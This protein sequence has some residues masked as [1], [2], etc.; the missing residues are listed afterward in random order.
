MNG[1]F[2]ISASMLKLILLFLIGL[3]A[4]LANVHG[5][6]SQTPPHAHIQTLT[7]DNL[8]GLISLVG[9]E[10]GKFL[11]GAALDSKKL[12]TLSRDP[13][14]G[15]VKVIDSIGDLEG[16]VCL[17]ISKDQKWVVFTSCISSLVTL[18]SR[19]AETGKLTEA[20]R[21]QQGMDGVKGLEWPIA[22]TISP[23]SKF[24]YVTNDSGMGSL[25]A[26]SIENDQLKFLQKHEGVDGCMKGAR[27]LS[28]DPDGEFLFVASRHANCLTVFDRDVEKG[29]L[30]FLDHLPDG[31][32]R[33]NLL[34][35]AH[36]VICSP[37]GRH[38][39]VTSGR[40]SGDQGISV[41][42][43]LQREV[44]EL[45]QELEGGKDL[46][47]FSGGNFINISSDGKYV[48]ATGFKSANV[49][50][51]ERDAKSGRLE[52]LYDLQVEGNSKIGKAAG[53]YISSD[54]RFVYVAHEGKE[55]QL[56]VFERQLE[57]VA[58]PGE[59]EKE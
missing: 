40:W 11:Y 31:E 33:R 41:F 56:Y 22:V 26:F 15:K 30:R 4:D 43:I 39:Y 14:T 2:R 55:N 13:K 16:A 46:K 27:L 29:R 49:I 51:L 19:D 1:L 3:W 58:Q 37:D 50:C 47:D 57:G 20:S 25:T 28:V 53:V 38:L 54:N 59:V 17:A 45:V 24:V 18:Y 12:V 44:L 36:G 6:E 32:D 10:D 23:D 42:D 8:N 34:E 52:Y 48:Y 21:Q 35:G 7:D 9:S 5:Q